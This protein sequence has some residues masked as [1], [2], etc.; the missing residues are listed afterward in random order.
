V[1]IYAPKTQ[2]CSIGTLMPGAPRQVDPGTL[3]DIANVA[4]MLFG[5]S[6][7]NAKNG[8]QDLPAPGIRRAG[9]YTSRGGLKVEIADASVVLDCAEAHIR[10]NNSVERTGSQILVHI[11]NA[12]SPFTATFQPD[13]SLLGPASVAIAGRLVTGMTGD[14]INYLT[15]SAQCSVG[16]LFP[17]GG[18]AQASSGSAST[19]ARTTA[20]ASVGVIPASVSSSTGNAALSVAS[21]YPAGASLVAGRSI[22]LMKDRLINLLKGIGLHTPVGISSSQAWAG[23]GAACR[24][25]SK[26][27]ALLSQIAK[28][29]PTR[30]VMPANGRGAFPS[31]VPAGIY[32]VMTM[33]TVNKAALCWNVPVD[34]K[35]G[36]NSVVLDN[37]TRNIS[38]DP[39]LLK[40]SFAVLSGRLFR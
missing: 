35:P 37:A 26:C 13:G 8:G 24:P 27:T 3:T 32:Y 12:A 23:I 25:A 11:Q 7:N 40:I 36:A 39:A 6:T 38:S 9:I 21:G 16:R 15:R 30:F 1:P 33:A 19:P 10:D 5:Q 22:F 29:V 18:S 14:Q 2:S 34:L 4:G 20:T 31:R 28:N 17:N